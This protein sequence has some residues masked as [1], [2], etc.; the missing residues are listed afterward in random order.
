MNIDLLIS[1]TNELVSC[2]D[3]PLFLFIDYFQNLNIVL[4]IL[5]MLCLK[6]LVLLHVMTLF[7][8]IM[9]LR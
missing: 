3:C 8:L 1:P 5:D 4:E 9:M 6:Y 2:V 7:N